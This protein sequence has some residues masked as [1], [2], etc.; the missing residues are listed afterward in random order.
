M[1]V[2]ESGMMMDCIELQ[3][4]N[5]LAGILVTLF[6]IFTVERLVQLRKV[7]LLGS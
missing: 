6:P 3:P 4:A 5:K 2:T 7:Q 1:D